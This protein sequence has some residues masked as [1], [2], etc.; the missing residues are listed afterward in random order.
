MS[1]EHFRIRIPS[2]TGIPEPMRTVLRELFVDLQRLIVVPQPSDRATDYNLTYDGTDELV[3]WAVP[4]AAGALDLAYGE[5][6]VRA[7]SDTISPSS[8]GWTLVDGFDTNG[9]SF[10]TTPNAVSNRITVARTGTYLVLFSGDWENTTT[11]SFEL[12]IQ[13]QK[14]GGAVA[15]NNLY[16]THFL[17]VGTGDVGDNQNMSLSGIVSLTANDYIQLFALTNDVTARTIIMEN[18]NLSL[19]Q[20]A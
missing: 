5:I 19:V 7:N 10:E 17:P 2:L 20:L 12:T 13:V 15:F 18:S 9:A 4:A 3:A 6:S 1:I 14:N 16:S 8:S 11:A